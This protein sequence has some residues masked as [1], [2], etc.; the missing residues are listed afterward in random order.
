MTSEQRSGAQRPDLTDAE[1][2]PGGHPAS[3]NSAV[4]AGE[5]LSG[6]GPEPD[7]ALGARSPSDHGDL[8]DGGRVDGT[9]GASSPAD[10]GAARRDDDGEGY[11]VEEVV[12]DAIDYFGEDP[13]IVSP[14][15]ESDTPAPG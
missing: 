6:R 13:S 9:V 15:S 1:T 10:R 8:L 11:D 12:E 2:A 4:S 14:A 7:G 3:E 5:A